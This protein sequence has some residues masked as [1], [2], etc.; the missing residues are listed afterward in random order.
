MTP[1]NPNI[2]L[3]SDKNYLGL[4]KETIELLVFKVFLAMVWAL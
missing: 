3:S 1:V 2:E 4:S